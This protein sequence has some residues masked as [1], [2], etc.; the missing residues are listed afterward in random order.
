[1]PICRQLPSSTSEAQLRDDAVGI[2]GRQ[3]R[4]LRK[5]PVVARDH[6]VDLAL[7][8]RVPDTVEAR[9]RG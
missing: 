6:V 9:Q 4:D 7:V 1:M 8:H 3:V 2:A 5:G